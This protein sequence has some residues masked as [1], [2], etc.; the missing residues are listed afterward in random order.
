[1]T[2]M[3]HLKY[4]WIS[5]MFFLLAPG[6]YIYTLIDERGNNFFSF[7]LVLW[8]ALGLFYF[9]GFRLH[10]SY[11]Q[12]EKHKKITI[13]NE[14]VTINDSYS[15]IIDDIDSIT[16]HQSGIGGNRT[17]WNDYEFSVIRLKNG[18]VFIITCLLMNFQTIINVFPNKK[19]IRKN[20]FI[21]S[22]SRKQ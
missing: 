9:I 10:F 20:H 14:K 15:F 22:L 5:L 6:F 2:F 18:K 21:A 7:I 16:N 17:P 1:M 8:L 3:K 4:I 13:D 19:I 12:Y 11:Y